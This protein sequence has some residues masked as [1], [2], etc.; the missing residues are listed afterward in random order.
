MAKK[1]TKWFKQ[2]HVALLAIIS[3]VIFGSMNKPKAG[4]QLEANPVGYSVLA[5]DLHNFMIDSL[6]TQRYEGG[7]YKKADLLGA[8]LNTKSDSIYILNGLFGC[9]AAKGTGLAVTSPRDTSFA[10]VSRYTSAT[11]SSGSGYCYPCPKRAC[12]PKK[13]CIIN[14][15]RYKFEYQMYNPSAKNQNVSSQ[16]SSVPLSEI[17]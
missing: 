13:F 4:M 2:N 14:T 7:L 15:D 17:Q 9:I 16:N 1:I 11:A 5:A 12:C 3:F 6:S 8:I 10:F